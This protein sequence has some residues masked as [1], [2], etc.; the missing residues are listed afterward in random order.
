MSLEKPIEAIVFSDPF[1]RQHDNAVY[2]KDPTVP[3][4]HLLS[5][6]FYFRQ[7]I[8]GFALGLNVREYW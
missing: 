4:V 3:D 7:A 1:D 2:L 8:D 6:S 5:P